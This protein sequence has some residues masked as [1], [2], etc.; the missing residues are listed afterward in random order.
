MVTTTRSPN[1]YFYFVKKTLYI[2]LKKS[3]IFSVPSPLKGK[4][5]QKFFS[6]FQS[7][8]HILPIA[9]KKNILD[10]PPCDTISLSTY[11]SSINDLIDFVKSIPFICTSF[12]PS[13][14]YL[15]ET[16]IH[17]SKCIYERKNH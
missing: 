17:K 13:S 5:N 2:Y 10:H 14:F 1:F 7:F 12:L 15:V 3:C 6:N 4:K 16:T 9:R 8:M 11:T